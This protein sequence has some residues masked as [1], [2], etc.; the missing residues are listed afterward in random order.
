MGA[1]LLGVDLR[2]A[3]LS[4]AVFDENAFQVT[5]DQRTRLD[6]ASGSVFRP[7]I[8]VE[9]DVSRELA[10]AE[11]QKWIKDHGGDIRVLSSDR[12]V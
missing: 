7:A 5:L 11:L 10:G 4:N 3:D 12:Q 8:I 6:G 9:N 1:S 2:S